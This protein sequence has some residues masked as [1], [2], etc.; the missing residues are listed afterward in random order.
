MDNTSSIAHMRVRDLLNKTFL[1]FTFGFFS[2]LCV[3]FVILIITGALQA[4]QQEKNTQEVQATS[5]RGR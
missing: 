4:S 3:S 5:T 2:I 1:R